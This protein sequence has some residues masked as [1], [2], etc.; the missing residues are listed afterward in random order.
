MTNRVRL[1]I[2]AFSVTVLLTA[3]GCGPINKLRA[4]DNLNEGV[5]EFNKGKYDL[6][7]AKFERALDLSPDLTNAQLFYARAV[8]ARF[9]QNQTE[10]FGLLT[11]EAYDNIINRNQDRPEEVNRALAFKSKVFEQLAA[12]NPEK[13]D[14]YHD[15]REQALLERASMPSANDQTRADVYYTL[16]V[17]YWKEVYEATRRHTYADGSLRE[18]MPPEQIERLKPKLQK[19]H[20][21]LQ[22]AISVKADYANAYFYES[23][24][25]RQDALIETNPEA[26][27]KIRTNIEE[28]RNKYMEMQGQKPAG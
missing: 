17:S 22:R 16:G 20:E 1:A 21:Y 18:P 3:T 7:Q 23:L 6:A 27:K 2:T 10:D 5:R 12:I 26:L 4:K 13:A 28:F 11:L 15:K 14:E 8:N 19:A 25:Y 9:E 24:A